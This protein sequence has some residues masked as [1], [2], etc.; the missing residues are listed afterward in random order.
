M[1]LM[2][3]SSGSMRTVQFPKML[4]FPVSEKEEEMS[5]LSLNK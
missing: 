3:I 2:A 4:Q 1:M 5:L